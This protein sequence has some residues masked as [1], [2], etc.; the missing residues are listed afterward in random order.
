MIADVIPIAAPVL[1]EE[2][3]Q[4]LLE[5]LD[6]GWV[7]AGPRVQRFEE[8]VAER[9]GVAHAVAVS[10]GTAALE[11][12]LAAAGL[13]AGDVV[14]VPS[15]TFV[16]CANAVVR[17]GGTVRFVDVD[18]RTFNIDVDDLERK[19]PGAA[20][21]LPV[22]QFGRPADLRRIQQL[23]EAE[24][25]W[26]IEDAACALGTPG[27]GRI[28]RVST[29]SFH[30]RKVITTG[31]GGMVVTA[32]REVAERARDLRNHG[33]PA[34]HTAPGCNYRLS[35]LHA[36]LG[37]VQMGRLDGLLADR[38]GQA[39][40]YAQLFDEAG[41]S[42]FLP[43]PDGEHAW[44][45]YVGLV[46]EDGP[47]RDD[48]LAQLADRGVS[49]RIGA[50]ACHVL[51]WC[52]EASGLSPEDLPGAWAAHRRS[53]ALPLFPGLSPEDQSRVVQAMRAL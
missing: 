1:G 40:R 12:G 2:E 52:A 36:A 32:D 30:P 31:E 19:L 3:G 14:V 15:F 34:G 6:S 35:D 37:V 27:I 5:V 49:A 9:L 39:E 46:S 13:S 25:A 33:A 21:V 10:S 53:L 51:P 42:W 28:G 8:L 26:V 4:A 48:V 38:R 50:T 47:S 11:V 41:I 7:M 16:A 43:P 29:L 45:S 17:W 23:C 22:H 24:G 44:Q 20:A 18:P